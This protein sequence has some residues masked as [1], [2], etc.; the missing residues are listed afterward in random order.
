MVSSFSIQIAD[1]A[2][3]S[4]TAGRY[5]DLNYTSATVYRQTK[6]MLDVSYE[7]KEGFVHFVLMTG[8]DGFYSYFVN[9]ALGVQG[10]FR[11]L[12]RLDPTLF[13]NGRTYLKDEP[14]PLFSDIL[15]GTNVQDET[16]QRPDGTYITKYDWSFFVRE[17]DFHGVYG[18]NF[19]AWVIN[20][21]KDYYNGDQLKQE[22]SVHRESQTNDAVLLNMLHGTH[23]QAA[24]SNVIPVGKVFGPWL[25]LVLSV[26]SPK[27][28]DFTDCWSNVVISTMAQSRMLSSVTR[29]KKKPGHTNGLKTP[30]TSPAVPSQENS[31]SITANPLQELPSSSVSPE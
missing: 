5:F 18:K 14:L 26:D 24:F 8:L 16:W 30:Y 25:V 20:P 17:S 31:S 15:N 12:Y 6:D 23:F 29:L 9:K 27:S 2:T 19:G 7:A 21:G 4:S 10:E 22:L 11:T 3:N 13:P 28:K 1:P